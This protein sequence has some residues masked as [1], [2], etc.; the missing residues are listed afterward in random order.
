MKISEIFHC[1]KC[2]YSCDSYL[3]SSKTRIFKIDALFLKTFNNII[4]PHLSKE[5]DK[6]YLKLRNSNTGCNFFK[7]NKGCIFGDLKP[8]VCQVRP[9]LIEKSGQLILEPFCNG[10]QN[11]I[12]EL[13][14]NN[15]EVINYTRQAA[16]CFQD[17]IIFKEYIMNK[18]KGLILQIRLGHYKTWLSNTNIDLMGDLKEVYY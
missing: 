16:Q 1:Q 12:F 11:F 9:I 5:G 8:K 10:L 15:Q 18:T 7:E 14:K 6:T 17:D 13:Q 3:G 4:E 2:K